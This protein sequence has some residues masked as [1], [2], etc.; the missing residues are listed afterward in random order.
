MNTARF[1]YKALLKRLATGALVVAGVLFLLA[2]SA[3]ALAQGYATDDAEL[4]PGMVAALSDGSTSEDPKVQRASDG[5]E[6][7]II[8]VVTTPGEGL[9]TVV[10]GPDQV[11]VQTTG[12]VDAYV[13]DINGSVEQGDL[14]T[15][16]PLR[17]ILMKA[18]ENTATVV[19]TALESMGDEQAD[20][21]EIEG[22]DVT[23]DVQLVKLRIN[24]DHRAASNQQAGVTDSSLN[25]IG[26]AVTGRNVADVRVLAALAIFVIVLVAEGGI[27]YGA[28]SSTIT[29][30]GRNPMARKI[31]IKEVVRVLLIAMAVLMMGIIA[32]YGVLW[33]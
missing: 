21:L 22:G 8:G 28:V 27:I 4:R 33:I 20:N 13:S 1:F 26:R 11:Y 9:V 24:L 14:L 5:N 32:I 18:G 15:I 16:S 30:L 23:R 17:G 25:R 2:H 7:R 10:S 19:G 31:I 6:D 3:A 12:E 29:A